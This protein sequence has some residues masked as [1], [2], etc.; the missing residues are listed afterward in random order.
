MRSLAL[1]VLLAG[2]SS[3]AFA[4]D[5]PNI[6]GTWVPVSYAGA[7]IGTGGGVPDSNKPTF[8]TGVATAWNYVIDKQDGAA[9]YGAS[10]SPSGEASIFV[11]VF[12]PDGK[13][14]WTSTGR[15]N[16]EGEIMGDQLEICW[17][18]N[19][20]KYVGV[21]CAVYKRQ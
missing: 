7:Y 16:H 13:H 19:V 12:G 3:A 18:D 11:G 6:V 4:A 14:F 17:T 9:F 20:E 21:S 1:A 15:G 5:P 10:R 8:T 2:I